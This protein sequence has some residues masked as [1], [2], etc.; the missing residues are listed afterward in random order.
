M[1]TRILIL[2]M[3]LLLLLS[4][5][6]LADD[7]SVD[8]R[9]RVT[10]YAGPGGDVVIPGVLDGTEV[11]GLNRRAL[12][13]NASIE[14]LTL[15]EG[16]QYLGK[17]ATYR[18]T[19]LSAVRLPDSLGAIDEANFN[20]CPLLTEVILPPGLAYIGQSSFSFDEALRSVTFTGP[21]PLISPDAFRS[22][23]EGFTAYVPDDLVADYRAALPAHVLVAPSGALSA[24]GAEAAPETDFSFDPERGMITAYYGHAAHL[25]IP[26][27]IGGVPVTTIDEDALD[28]ADDTYSVTLPDSIEALEHGLFSSMLCLARI[29]LPATLRRV[30]E[31]TF[32]SVVLDSLT[33]PASVKVIEEEAFERAK[34]GTLIFNSARIPVFD[35]EAFSDASIGR[36]LIAWDSTDDELTAA[37]NALR[38]AGLSAAVERAEPP[39]TA[40]PAV[41]AAPAPEMTEA[42]RVVPSFPSTPAP[43]ERRTPALTAAPAPE[44][45]E[46]PSATEA[47]TVTEAPTP[48]PTVIALPMPE[49]TEAPSA[50]EAPQER[51]MPSF[52]STP[53]P[54]ER[55]APVIIIAPATPAPTAVPVT[56]APTATP[57]TV[58]DDPTRAYLGYWQGES[59]ILWGQ[60]LS[61][62]EI[63]ITLSLT[64]NADGTGELDYALPD[65]GKTWRWE[66]GTMYYDGQPLKLTDDGRLQYGDESEGILVFRRDPDRSAPDGDA[67]TPASALIGEWVGTGIVMDGKPLDPVALGIPLR[68][69]LNADYTG[70]L[71]YMVS[72]GGGHWS[73]ENGEAYYEGMRLILQENGE[74][75]LCP[76]VESYMVFSA[77]K[78]NN[79]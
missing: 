46:A 61:P 8:T 79:E 6:A 40:A 2:S 26:G 78:A 10:A 28:D 53:A 3:V 59:L 72:D 42:P 12:M 49:M 5:G 76:S 64:L 70:E 48:V 9:H 67:Q 73:A 7:L 50:T 31:E 19:A 74:L 4:A 71:C 1:R 58:P 22:T 68:L 25:V 75:R 39:L 35:P 43:R 54:R 66:N 18:M 41:T 37:A 60:A 30:G 63:G 77:E 57:A 33:L 21:A 11:W 45:T 14:T 24:A 52:P 47:P 29:E 23:I 20:G 69:T 38:V 51:V 32:K 16:V 62:E 13:D 15:E 55:K 44:M 27:D 17:S 56:P 65:G 34:I 36:V